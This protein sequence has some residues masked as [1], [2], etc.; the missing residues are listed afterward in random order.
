MSVEQERIIDFVIAG[1]LQRDTILPIKR[2]PT[3]DILGGGLAYASAGLA[4]WGG[5]AGLLSKISPDFPKQW[6][7]PIKDA[8]FSMDGIKTSH[9]IMDMR[10]FVAYSD[11]QTALYD[12]PITQFANRGL[13]FPRELLNYRRKSGLG[14]DLDRCDPNSIG[15]SDIPGNY[16]ETHAAHICPINLV[17]HQVL[18]NALKRGSVQTVTM[19]ACPGYMDPVYW[20]LIP[21]LVSDL[22]A[23]MVEEADLRRLFQGR[24]T[25]L[26]EMAVSISRHGPEFVLIRMKDGGQ[27]LFDGVSLKKWAIPMYSSNVVDPTGAADAFAGGFLI[28]YRQTY[29]A[30][31]A[32]LCGNVTASFVMESC[33]PF[34]VLGAMPGL[35]EARLEALKD[36]VTQM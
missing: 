8:G 5:Q 19:S 4:F 24:S 3:I 30:V 10:W 34:Y 16:L 32:A 22:T 2:S 27:Y 17:S 20:E 33:G 23:F 29:D 18:P 21:S 6:L 1:K 35:K 7:E 13:S 36:L 25:D 12:S 26:W 31:Y 28:N 14:E 15:I 9:E 11:P